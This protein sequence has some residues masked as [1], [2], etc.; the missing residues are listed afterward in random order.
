MHNFDDIL[1]QPLPSQSGFYSEDFDDYEESY[2]DIDQ[3]DEDGDEDD[4]ED[5]SWK[6][7]EECGDDDFDDLDDDF[8]GLSDDDI[9]NE[10]D[11]VM[12]DDPDYPDDD[13]VDSENPE[14]LEGEEDDRANDLLAISATPMILKDE[15]T[16]EEAADFYS[17]EDADIAISEGLLMES[18]ID[19]L[20]T[21]SP[22][23]SPNQ[24]FKMTKQARFNQ[25]YE[26]SVQIE[27]RMHND[28]YYAKLQKAYKI[29][30]ICKQNLRKK[31][32]S[33]AIKRAKL[34][35]KRLMHSKSSIL[36]KVGKKIGLK[37]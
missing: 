9:A 12:D 14:P 36:N 10:L 20:Y 24:K 29:E 35:L 8:G 21:E 3:Y 5:D 1:N 23:A 33:F 25:L 22:F 26:L 31:Y 32:H 16:A 30:R 6:G 37:K 17:T 2:D 18:A 28:P 19:E 34:Y 11:D 27:G 15:L 13:E 7:A 4:G